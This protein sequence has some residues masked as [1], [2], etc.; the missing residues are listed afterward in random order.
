[1]WVM[2]AVALVAG[3][4]TVR[5]F[6]SGWVEA[7][8]GLEF[9]LAVGVSAQ[10]LRLQ[11]VANP[12]DR[13]GLLAAGVVSC[14]WAA[15]DGVALLAPDLAPISDRLP[16]TPGANVL[17]MAVWTT[18]TLALTAAVVCAA[19]VSRIGEEEGLVSF[20]WQRTV[21]GVMSFGR[22]VMRTVMA[23][24]AS[25]WVLSVVVALA[26]A[27]TMFRSGNDESAQRASGEQVSTLAEVPKQLG[28]SSIDG[29]V[30]N[31]GSNGGEE[32]LGSTAETAGPEH[33][34][35]NRLGEPPPEGDE[36]RSDATRSDDEEL[37][38]DP[39]TGAGD[40]RAVEGSDWP[41]EDLHDGLVS[42][43]TDF[44][45]VWAP[46]FEW[47][48]A[49]V[50]PLLDEAT[51]VAFRRRSDDALLQAIFGP[52]GQAAPIDPAAEV[53]FAPYLER[54]VSLLDELGGYPR[55]MYELRSG[56]QT[57][58][59][60]DAEGGVCALALRAQTEDHLSDGNSNFSIIPPATFGGWIDLVRETGVRFVGPASEDGVTVTQSTLE[61]TRI[62]GRTD[63]V[64][65]PL[66]IS[67]LIELLD[68]VPPEQEAAAGESNG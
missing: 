5:E 40:H 13:P 14:T 16:V 49:G 18:S 53:A 29:G 63:E 50:R 19:A 55:G 20:A 4:Y 34:D 36:E 59:I 23:L 41:R 1:M 27:A 28:R 12:D 64:C 47:S 17:R 62:S 37:T 60:A 8:H 54:D 33:G 35:S 42:Q 46:L 58:P 68:P 11:S 66:P 31:E 15:V 67:E 43:A 10:V 3:L 52:D 30:A 57:I 39:A 6:A 25:I 45:A 21:A 7:L 9:M 51:A 65:E 32:P 2:G 22:C 24:R 61:G 26:L 48:V 44:P 38:E 56:G